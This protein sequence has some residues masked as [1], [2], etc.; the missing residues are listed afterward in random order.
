MYGSFNSNDTRGPMLMAA[1]ALCAARVVLR[2]RTRRPGR[3]QF[4]ILILVSAGR[5]DSGARC[6]I[7]GSR[8]APQEHG[9]VLASRGRWITIS[10][11][12]RP[13]DSKSMKLGGCPGA[14]AHDS[15]RS[16]YE[17]LAIDLTSYGPALHTCAPKKR[18]NDSHEYQHTHI[19]YVRF[20]F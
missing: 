3:R 6:W 1:F 5:L 11:T 4:L 9:S 12:T 16:W 2:T 13:H 10:Q 7:Y 17:R 19:D 14:S 18:T 15:I 20:H 8:Y